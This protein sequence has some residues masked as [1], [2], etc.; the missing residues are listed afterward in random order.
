M[1]LPAAP[2]AIAAAVMAVA[3]TGVSALQANAQAKYQAKIAD[4]NASLANESAQQEILNT[5]EEAMAHYRKVAALKGQ[6]RVAAAANGVALDFGTAADVLADT[7]MLGRED[8][9]RIYQQ[10]NQRVRG[11][12]IEASNYGA[13]ADAQRQAATGALVKGVFDMGSTAL[14]AASQYKTLKANR[15][16][17]STGGSSSGFGAILPSS[18]WGG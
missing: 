16:F 3:S 4:R 10:G 7:E 2:L 12:E 17:G 14:S 13:E 11:Y 18:R 6:Q 1:C 5:R 8:V 15:G 9:G